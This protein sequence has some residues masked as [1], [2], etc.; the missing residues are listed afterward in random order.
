MI[1]QRN[2]RSW[3]RVLTTFSR[4]FK[5]NQVRVRFAPSPTGHLHLGGL[6][7]ALYNYLFAVSNNGKMILRIEDTDQTRKVDGAM[8]ALIENLSWA[9]INFHEGPTH[10][11][12]FG[13]YVQSE[14][15]QIYQY[16]CQFIIFLFC[17]NTA[18]K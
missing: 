4:S 8:E 15:L 2:C 5:T 16:V 11:G 17:V 13:P 7:T 12:E 10:G 9:G 18:F 14:R 3:A 1:A 6:R